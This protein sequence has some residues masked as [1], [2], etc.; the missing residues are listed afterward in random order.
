[1]NGTKIVERG[2]SNFK[3][4]IAVTVRCICN[5]VLEREH[6]DMK[7]SVEFI[8][9]TKRITL[10]NATFFASHFVKQNYFM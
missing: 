1:M 4:F 7:L 9:C 6:F 10:C 5:E 2:G 8:D 3:S